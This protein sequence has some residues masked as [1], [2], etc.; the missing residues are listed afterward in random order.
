MNNTTRVLVADDDPYAQRILRSVVVAEGW[1]PVIASDGE[2]AWSYFNADA[3]AFSLVT[4]DV[5]M[6][7]LDGIELCQRIRE[8]SGIPILIVS[9][10]SSRDQVIAGVEAWADDYITKPIDLE[11]L[12]AKMRRALSR[13]NGEGR[14]ASQELVCGEIALDASSH[15]ATKRGVALTLTALEYR[16]LRYLLENQ[17]LVLTHQQILGGV[18]GETHEGEIE[19]LRAAISRLRGKMRLTPSDQCQLRTH[20]AIGY[21][22]GVSAGDA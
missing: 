16:L 2:E 10:L 9:G 14:P 7:K 5:A 11:V 19:V 20:V 1:E 4:I 8:T 12:T 3:D 18:W 15:L 17:R 13:W 22:L 21:S 6:P